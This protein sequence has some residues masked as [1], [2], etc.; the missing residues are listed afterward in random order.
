MAKISQQDRA[1]VGRWS[2]GLSIRIAN[3]SSVGTPKRD[4][5]GGAAV[6]VEFVRPILRRAHPDLAICLD[7]R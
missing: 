2:V 1:S 4:P 6:L 7:L 3:G 5:S